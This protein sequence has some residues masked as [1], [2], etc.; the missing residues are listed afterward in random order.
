[1]S[2]PSSLEKAERILWGR[3]LRKLRER[4]GTT[5]YEAASS[6]RRQGQKL[7]E[8]PTG[9]SAQRWQQF[10][11]GSLQ[12]TADQIARV[13]AALGSNP[14]ELE[15][16]RAKLTGQRQRASA[17]G[18]VSEG[19]APPMVI[20][21]FG[22]AQLAD[23]G[24]R[25]RDADQLDGALDLRDLL[26]PSMGVMR[27]ADETMRGWAEPGDLVIFDRNRRPQ[28][29]KGCVVETLAGDLFPR[30]FVGIDAEHVMVRS[31]LA[32]EPFAFRR[33]E[34]KGVYAVR[35]RGD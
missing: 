32:G 31:M 4:S 2:E 21:I 30:L 27:V 22:R 29:D 34:I 25:V 11:K 7:T 33:P 26:T 28:P 5:I 15:L 1:M 13:T 35:F 19:P 3:A 10:E 23:E 9:I 8:T 24:W 6:I 17:Y 18:G 16:E 12:F 14:D 20:P